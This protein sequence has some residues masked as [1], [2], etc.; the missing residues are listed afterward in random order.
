MAHA[1]DEEETEKC[2]QCCDDNIEFADAA[3]LSYFFCMSSLCSQSSV[4]LFYIY[5]HI[6]KQSDVKFALRRER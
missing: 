6:I 4:C 5:V 3:L 1:H 2:T